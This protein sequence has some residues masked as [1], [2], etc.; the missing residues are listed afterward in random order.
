MAQDNTQKRRQM[1]RE[2]IIAATKLWDALQELAELKLERATAGNFVDADFEAGELA[3]LTPFMIG[4]LIDTHAPDI[5]AFVE[6]AGAPARL[7]VILGVRQ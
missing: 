4:S 1:A 7:D 6:D 3:H 5:K 2:A